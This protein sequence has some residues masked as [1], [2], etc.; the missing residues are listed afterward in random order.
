MTTVLGMLARHT[1]MLLFL[2]VGIGAL[3]GRIKIKGVSLGGGAVLFVAIGV[4]AWGDANGI[5]I[6]VAPVIGVI[7]LSVFTF[8]VGIASGPNFFHTLK[9]SLRAVVVVVLAILV[10]AG[11]AF[12]LAGF[13][14]LNIPEALGVFA[15]AVTNTP[16]LAAI[17]GDVQAESAAT[18]GY[19]VS[20]LFG[21]LGMLAIQSLALRHR[22]ADADTPSP[23]VHVDVLVERDD[24]PHVREV[25]EDYGMQI[26]IT[27]LHHVGSQE[28]TL[29][30]SREVMRKGDIATVVG[31]Q[32]VVAEATKFLGRESEKQLELDRSQLD[33]RRV[34][35]SDPKVSGHSIRE[36]DLQGKFGGLISRVRRG[37][38]DMVAHPDLVLQLG[39]RVR[40]VAPRDKI[41]EISQFLG[42]SS[43][44]MSNI[45]PVALGLGLALGIGIGMIPIPLPSGG[46]FTFGPA[47]GALVV[48]LA[49]GRIGRIGAFPTALP[50]T[51]TATLSEFGMLLFLAQAGARAGGQIRLAFTSGSWLSMLALGAIITL[52]IGGIIYCVGHFL[53]HVGGTQLAGVLAGAQTQPALLGYANTRTDHDFRVAMGYSMAYPS[54]MVAKI[55]AASLL[56]VL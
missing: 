22:H 24:E 49:M 3:I 45:N 2:L 46:T 9:T 52:V 35:L 44:G 31:P 55:L 28:Q 40:V 20:Y 26:N 48:G 42:D 19:S 18:V 56:S 16:A 13:F 21:V 14:G 4:G 10:G 39:D 25:E 36:I 37:D 5:K 12:S 6:E 43:H 1:E 30:L 34:T 15:G 7:G 27:R 50:Y 32:R 11:L 54:A 51:A 41:A 23:I 17:G 38:V 8:V 33:F 47:V 53:L 29:A